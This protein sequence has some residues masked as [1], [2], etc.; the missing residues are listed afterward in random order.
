MPVLQAGKHR[1]RL[2]LNLL[3][4]T[5]YIETKVREELRRAYGSTLPR[6]DVMSTLD[7]NRG[8]LLM[9]ELSQQLMVSNGNITGI[10]D[11]LV[12]EKLVR[13][14]AVVGDRRATRVVLTKSGIEKFAVMAKEH[15]SWLNEIL[16]NV[17]S[18]QSLHMI[19]VLS[20]IRKDTH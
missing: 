1:L 7:R 8:G 15:E 19:E 11:R 17:D 5:R 4:T 13:R 9:S 12:E 16:K 10:I 14:L 2:W 20:S 6:F 3:R 18:T